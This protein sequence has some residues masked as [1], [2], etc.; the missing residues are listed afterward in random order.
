M[1]Y[2]GSSVRFEWDEAKDESN[3]RKHGVSFE[4]ASKLFTSGAEYLEL[5]DS[6]H[7]VD[8]DRFICIG[9]VRRVVVM[10]EPAEDC[11]RIISARWATPR[12]EAL[13]AEHLTG[14][15]RDD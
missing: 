10:T 11:V 14:V 12:E 9:L 15:L 1:A 6:H 5:F 3:Q 8:E 7:S 2:T 13:L 4:E